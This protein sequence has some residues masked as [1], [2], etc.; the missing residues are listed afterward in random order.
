MV[1]QTEYNVGVVTYRHGQETGTLDADWAVSSQEHGIIRR[2]K[3]TGGPSVGYVGAYFIDYYDE[4]GDPD[5]SF[6]LT[7]TQNQSVYHLKW[8]TND[9]LVIKGSGVLC[10]D[11]LVVGWSTL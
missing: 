2:G 10:E 9:Q 3:A 4:N 6:K 7:I 8:F 11:V 1:N 5:D